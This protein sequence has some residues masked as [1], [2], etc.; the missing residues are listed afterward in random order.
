MTIVEAFKTGLPVRRPSPK[1]VGST[2]DGWVSR[3]YAVQNLIS[4]EDVLAT[5]WEVLGDLNEDSSN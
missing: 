4:I 5:D 3:T 1:Y 2:G